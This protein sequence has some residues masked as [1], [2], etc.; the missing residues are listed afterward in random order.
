MN[1][2]DLIFLIS[3][4]TGFAVIFFFWITWCLYFALTYLVPFSW[5]PA[6]NLNGPMP[7]IEKYGV[8]V[9]CLRILMNSLLMTVVHIALVYGILYY[10]LPQYLSKSKNRVGIIA[11]LIVFAIMIACFNYLNFL[12]TFSISTRMGYFEKMP[13][14]NYIIP[15]LDQANCIQLSNHS[16]F[17]CRHQT[18]ET[19]V[20]ETKRN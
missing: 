1:Y 16:R 2:Y 9:S 3:A 13:D 8:I 7:Q 19:L 12:M 10:F 14:M 6:W 15:I 20:P 18:F 4:N 11:L 17:C 5:V